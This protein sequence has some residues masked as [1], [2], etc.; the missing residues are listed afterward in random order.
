MSLNTLLIAT[1]YDKWLQVAYDYATRQDLS[2]EETKWSWDHVG[3]PL[4]NILHDPQYIYAVLACFCA[5]EAMDTAD[6]GRAVKD[7]LD[8]VELYKC[9][10]LTVAAEMFREKAIRSGIE[11][12]DEHLNPEVLQVWAR[13]HGLTLAYDAHMAKLRQGTEEA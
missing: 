4:V 10:Q 2:P 9:G 11:N 3:Q 13:E 5:A 1:T 12:P 7:D 8:N 6:R